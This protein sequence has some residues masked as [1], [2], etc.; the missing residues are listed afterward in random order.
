LRQEI[1]GRCVAFI[2]LKLIKGLT[3]EFHVTTLAALLTSVAM[4]VM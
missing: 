1:F 3:E 4:G 2:K